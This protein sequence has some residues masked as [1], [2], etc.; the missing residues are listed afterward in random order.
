M[1]WIRSF[2]LAA[3]IAAAIGSS[4]VP[5]WAVSVDAY[6]KWRLSGRTVR[7]TPTGLIS[8]HVGG[9]LQ[10]FLLVNRRLRAAGLPVLFCVPA[11]A[12]PD[13]MTTADLRK[14]IDKE[15]KTTSRPLSAPWPPKSAVA[16]V[17]L[18]IL[19]NEWPCPADRRTIP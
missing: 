11:T 5:A 10:G 14:L 9:V 16:T 13:G 3:L 15:L 12:P 7:A 17:I 6:Q 8:L 4:G 2:A 19:R 18:H 1:S